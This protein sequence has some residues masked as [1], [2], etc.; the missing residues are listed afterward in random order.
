MSWFTAGLASAAGGVIPGN[1]AVGS[2]GSGFADG[3]ITGTTGSVV[4]GGEVVVVEDDGLRLDWRKKKAPAAAMTAKA[5]AIQ[6]VG[7][8]CGPPCAVPGAGVWNCGGG[9]PIPGG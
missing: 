3:S 2:A 8:R 7:A 9:P 4:A 1:A 6:T 5:M